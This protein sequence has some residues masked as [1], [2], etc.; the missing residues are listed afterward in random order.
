[1]ENENY[2]SKPELKRESKVRL[3]KAATRIS[4]P[5]FWKALV[6]SPT[7]SSPTYKHHKQNQYNSNCQKPAQLKNSREVQRK[8]EGILHCKRVCMINLETIK[9]Q[10]NNSKVKTL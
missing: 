6:N 8:L 10:H 5:I 7:T 1:M 2:S 3:T 4:R 9:G